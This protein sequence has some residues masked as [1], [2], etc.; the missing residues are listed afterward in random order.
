[1]DF[2]E[3]KTKVACES[4]IDAINAELGYPNPKAD[5]YANIDWVPSVGATYALSMERRILKGKYDAVTNG[6]TLKSAVYERD[7]LGEIT[8]ITFLDRS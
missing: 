8:K 3:I 7:A 2:L 5:R 1:M 4:A 6:K